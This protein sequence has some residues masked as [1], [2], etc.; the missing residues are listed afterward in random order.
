MSQLYEVSPAAI[1]T[2]QRNGGSEKLNSHLKFP[3]L[4]NGKGR[5]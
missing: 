1:P 3:Q 4:A 5:V 2:S